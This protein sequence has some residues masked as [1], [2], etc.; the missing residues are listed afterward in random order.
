LFENIGADSPFTPTNIKDVDI[1][2]EICE[3]VKEK[4][5]TEKN[6]KVDEEKVFKLLKSMFMVYTGY[7]DTVNHNK[8]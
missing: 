7:I 2:A 1:Y 6:I 3:M 4:I 5:K 8:R